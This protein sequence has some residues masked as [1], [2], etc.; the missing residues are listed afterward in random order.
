M[1]SERLWRRYHC[2]EGLILT[3]PAKPHFILQRPDLMYQSLVLQIPRNIECVYLVDCSSE[4]VY[5][6]SL[7]SDST[8][9]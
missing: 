1:R 7:V 8:D 3:K 4:I 6:V 9:V 5:L 2:M